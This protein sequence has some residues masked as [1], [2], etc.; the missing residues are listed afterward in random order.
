MRYL[1]KTLRARTQRR[2]MTDAERRL[3]RILRQRQL[4]GC[5][6]RRQHPIGAYIVDFVCLERGVVI[7][8]DGSQHG[9]SGAD[10]VRD[11]FLRRQGFRILRVWNHDVLDN[12][13]GVRDAVAGLLA[14]ACVRERPPPRYDAIVRP[15][16]NPP[17]QSGGGG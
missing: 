14:G 9:V 12:L 3:W 6:F 15:H 4:M 5:R 7:E 11:A 17:P 2:Q 8:V 13:E 10:G 16:P 1:Q